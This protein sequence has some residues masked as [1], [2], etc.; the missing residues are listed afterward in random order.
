M[1][2]F[3]QWVVLAIFGAAAILLLGILLFVVLTRPTATTMVVATPIPAE[4]ALVSSGTTNQPALAVAPSVGSAFPNLFDAQ[5]TGKGVGFAYDIGVNEGQH[6]LVFGYQI[7]WEDK[8][9]GDPDKKG[10]AL[11]ELKP[12]WYP[13]LGIIDGRYEIRDLPTVGAEPWRQRLTLERMAEQAK[14]YGCA[15]TTY[16]KIPQWESKLPSPPE[17]VAAVKVPTVTPTATP[18]P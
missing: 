18:K 2:K 10:C 1:G 12:G 7:V 15:E 8:T 5:S 3:V 11:V 17:N 4:V 13:N 6:G 14:H 16:D 9:L